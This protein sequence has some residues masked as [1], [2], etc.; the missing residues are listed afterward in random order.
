MSTIRGVIHGKTIEL[1]DDPGIEDGR[2]VEVTIRTSS[3]PVPDARIAAILRTAG[4]LADDPE[5]AEVMNQVARQR[6]AA[7]FRDLAP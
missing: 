4:A 1:A 7:R 5:F 6:N 3:L 2:Q